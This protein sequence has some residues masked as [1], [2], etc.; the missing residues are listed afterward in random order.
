MPSKQPRGFN[1]WQTAPSHTG[2]W[3]N[4]RAVSRTI[5]SAFSPTDSAHCLWLSCCTAP[6]FR[7]SIMLRPERP[8]GCRIMS[9]MSTGRTTTASFKATS[10]ERRR[11]Q[12]GPRLEAVVADITVNSVRLDD[13]QRR[14]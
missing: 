5:S 2:A 14:V 13:I 1:I 10:T 9:R 4:P 3:A 8:G 6:E 7:R 11:N 12:N